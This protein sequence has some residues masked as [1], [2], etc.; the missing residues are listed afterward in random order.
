[1]LKIQPYE[2][3]VVWLLF[4][5]SLVIATSYVVARTIGDSLFLSRIGNEQL[6]LV[7]VMS[8]I[9][10]ALT[11]STWYFLTRR[12]SVSSTIQFSSL[13]FSVFTLAALLLL[14]RYHH[15]FWL[16]AAIYLLADIKGCINAINIVSALN[17]KLGRDASKP[18]WALVGLAAPTAAVLMGSVLAAES[19]VINVSTWLVV[20]LFLDLLAFSFG[21][22]L[23]RTSSVK[24]IIANRVQTGVQITAGSDTSKSNQDATDLR[25][26][27]F[28]KAKT[29]VCLTGFRR[30]I[31]ILIAAKVI[32]LTMFA[33]EWKTAV[34]TFFDG[35]TESLVRFFG[36]YY[37]VVG[38]ATI[39]LQLV[40][41]GKL[42]KE[43]NLSLP[44]LLMPLMLLAIALFIVAN[45]GLLVVL[46][47]AT[48]GKSLDAWRRS[49]HDTTLN[50][51]YT[52]I[53][54]G[55]RRFAISF[56]SGLVKPLSE[57]TA[58]S[59]IFLG[60]TLVYRSVL[61]AV[62]VVWLY[63]A[64]RLIHLINHPDNVAKADL[65][66]VAPIEKQLIQT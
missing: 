3:R 6:A 39:V 62:L 27:V 49:V 7:F 26:P 15:S 50:F 52:R 51:V 12:L 19:A 61:L 63:A 65:N 56:N 55:Q 36:T 2:K 54:R 40:V 14:P 58:S 9:A 44:L 47:L 5:F 8:G 42:L 25:N 24:D 59:I 1:M 21:V 10:T 23:G 33:F 46:L 22:A 48:L 37:G 29:Y 11:A 4:A 53:R 16:L 57:V 66:S 60:T 45:P 17:T 32:V 43:K 20:G 35:Q 41:T 18:A 28:S 64:W 31:G 13:A 34:N 30:W 38:L